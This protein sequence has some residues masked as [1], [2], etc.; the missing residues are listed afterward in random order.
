[1]VRDASVVRNS[2]LI[3]PLQTTLAPA[4]AGS[5]TVSV[6]V[7]SVAGYGRFLTVTVQGVCTIPSVWHPVKVNAVT[8]PL[9]GSPVLVNASIVVWESVH[10]TLARFVVNVASVD[11]PVI[12][13]LYGVHTPP[14]SVHRWVSAA[15]VPAPTNAMNAAAAIAARARFLIHFTG[16][17]PLSVGANAPV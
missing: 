8:S 7:V 1:M 6:V 12:S 14:A 17:S 4:P 5:L 16:Y 11:V 15:A 3:T 10:S 2:Q 9:I 13:P